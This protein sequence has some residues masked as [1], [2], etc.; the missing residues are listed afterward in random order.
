ME[1]YRN[2]VL[3]MSRILMALIFIGAGIDKM[4]RYA[5]TV[6]LMQSAGVSGSLLPAVIALELGGGLAILLGAAT[7]W[8]ALCLAMFC[9]V[10]AVLFHDNFADALQ[11]AM[12]MKNLAMAG[13]FLSL[14]VAGAG[15]ISI[16]ARK[17]AAR[18][19]MRTGT[20][21]PNNRDNKRGL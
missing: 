1:K 10:S 18:T 17:R 13:G 9:V 16:D 14:A 12:F 19:A 11:L 21:I 15:A 5:A 4:G 3:L 6:N 20:Y 7:C 2:T 8:A